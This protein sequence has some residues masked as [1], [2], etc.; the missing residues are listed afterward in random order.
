MGHPS[1]HER[2]HTWGNKMGMAAHLG[3][4]CRGWALCRTGWRWVR[5]RQQLGV[6]EADSVEACR[7]TF[8][9]L[10]TQCV[11][12]LVVPRLPEALAPLQIQIWLD[13]KGMGCRSGAR[14]HGR[15]EGRVGRGEEEEEDVHTGSCFR[16]PPRAWSPQRCRLRHRH[17]HRR[18]CLRVCCCC[19]GA[20][21][22]ARYVGAGA[23]M[24]QRWTAMVWGAH[25]ER[26]RTGRCAGRLQ[27]A[28]RRLGFGGSRLYTMLRRLD[29]SDQWWTVKNSWVSLG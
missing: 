10:G 26:R 2:W 17:P 20:G 19:G 14:R 8:V 28:A 12:Q 21:C 29:P 6:G 5:R 18:L 7:S 16:K 1:W 25:A 11:V 13:G 22:W 3:A 24:R 9:V 27:S 4:C 15:T 23:R